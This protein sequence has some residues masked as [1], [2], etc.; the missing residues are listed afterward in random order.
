[1]FTSADVLA[2][3]HKAETVRNALS[4]GNAALRPLPG[5]PNLLT[6][7]LADAIV[8]LCDF[9]DELGHAAD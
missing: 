4:G 3:R 6:W 1:M 2:V 9:I 5:N 7:E 8:R